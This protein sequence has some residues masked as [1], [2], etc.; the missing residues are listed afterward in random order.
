MPVDAS[1]ALG[2]SLHVLEGGKSSSFSQK[3]K[4]KKNLASEFSNGIYL[5]CSRLLSINI[6]LNLP[7]RGRVVQGNLGPWW[8]AAAGSG[9]VLGASHNG[10]GSWSGGRGSGNRGASQ[11]AMR[12]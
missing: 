12:M 3:G 2:M 1:V 8:A 11:G 4:K 5:C 9:A 10:Q 6:N 7:P